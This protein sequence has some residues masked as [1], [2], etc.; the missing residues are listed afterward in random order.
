MKIFDNMKKTIFYI[1]TAALCLLTACEKEPTMAEKLVGDW[2]CT[3][4]STDA[5][6]YVTFR[7]ENTFTL[8]QQIG[9]GAFRVYNGSY[10]LGAISDGSTYVLSGEYNDGTAWGT[11]YE[12]KSE[13]TNCFTLTG[14]GITE[15]Y[16]RME[17]GI[18]AEVIASSVT[19]VKS[20]GGDWKPFL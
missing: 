7:A 8:Y 14:E 12:L 5:E 1:F 18:P 3:A 17:T 16:D 15:T 13:D 9:E 20:E 6:I 10:R 19:V 4:A 2:H 11:S